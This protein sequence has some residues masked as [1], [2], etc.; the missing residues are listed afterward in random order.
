MTLQDAIEQYVAW[1][2]TRGSQ[3]V[4]GASI[5]RLYARSVGGDIACDAVRPD[6]ARTFLAG[7]GPLTRTRSVK[8]SA[9]NGFYRYA[10]GRGLATRSPL[11]ADEPPEPESAPPYIYSPDDLRRLFAAVEPCRR[12]AVQLDAPTFRTLLLLLYGAG[13]RLGEALRLTREDVALSS[14]VL[15]VR[16][17][18]FYQ[19]R[20]VPVGTDLG[21]ALASYAAIRTAFPPPD[22][23]VATFLANR[24]GSPLKQRTVHKAFDALRRHAGVRNA[25]GARYQPRLHDF[26]HTFATRRLESWYRQGADVQRLLPVLATYLGHVNLAGTQVYLTMTPELLRQAALRFQ[27]YAETG[28]GGRHV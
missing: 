28:I 5:L 26:R 16:G 1:R 10:L 11:P 18:K 20:F 23:G 7:S 24:D 4:S 6:Q 25:E 22:D 2:R 19:T 8:R 14:A 13:L 12:R 21:R 27:H 9:L 3:F 15:T 17:T